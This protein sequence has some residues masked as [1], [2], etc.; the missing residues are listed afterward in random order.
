MRD[1]IGS[2]HREL[3]GQVE[4]A[5]LCL[6]ARRVL[7]ALVLVYA[8]V[9]AA[10]ALT[11]EDLRTKVGDRFAWWVNTYFLPR[12]PLTATAVDL[13]A[14]RCAI[15]HT[16]TARSDLS[17]TGKAR[18]LLYAWGKGRAEDLTRINVAG[19]FGDRWAAVQV[20]DLINGLER[21]I[22]A[23]FDEVAVNPVLRARVVERG[24]SF[25]DRVGPE[26]AAEFADWYEE[27]LRSG[28]SADA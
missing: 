5:R 12:T 9:D 25:Y 24:D 10:A 14:A 28:D 7:P 1:P 8:G 13:F 19:G 4:A 6:A 15:L 17:E 20:E 2:A 18:R 21:G 16:L 23:V 22:A 26:G 3:A 11:V 27:H